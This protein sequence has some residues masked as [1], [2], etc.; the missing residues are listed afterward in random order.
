M[1]HDVDGRTIGSSVTDGQGALLDAWTVDLDLVGNVR[2]VAD[3]VDPA[4]NWTYTFDHLYQLT[5][6]RRGDGTD[7]SYKYDDAG[8]VVFRSDVGAVL[9]GENGHPVGCPTTVG[10]DALSYDAIGRQIDGPDGPSATTR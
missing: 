7:L 6:A 3:Q 10:A 8:N 1:D 4:R 2:G 9:Y 5:G